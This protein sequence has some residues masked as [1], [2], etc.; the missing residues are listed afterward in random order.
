MKQ[1]GHREGSVASLKM[2]EGRGRPQ[3]GVWTL[4]TTV[5]DKDGENV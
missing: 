4:R 3:S 1:T 5:E 2:G